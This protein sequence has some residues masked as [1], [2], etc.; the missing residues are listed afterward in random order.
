MLEIS[1]AGFIYSHKIM[2][3]Q[4][5]L[6]T[7]LFILT[8]ASIFL[9]S[10]CSS[11]T[12]DQPTPTTDGFDR[13]IMLENLADNI[14]IPS[15]NN[16]NDKILDLKISADNFSQNI[17]SDNL[18]DLRS[19]WLRAY[20]AWQH[21]E[22]FNIGK[23]EEIYYAF[24][25]NSYPADAARI[26][27]N[28]ES[29]SYDLV[30]QANNHDAQGFPAL[31]YMLYGLSGDSLSV[32]DKYL[33]IEG[34]KY[35]TYLDTLV[36]SM[37]NNT[38]LVIEYWNNNRNTFVSSYDNT[39]TS[40][41]NMLTNDFIYYYEKGL[42]A[43]KIGIPA[44]RYSSGPLSDKVEAYYRKNIS[45]ELALEALS[46]CNKFFIG[47]SFSSL[48]TGESLKTYLDYTNENSTLSDE[49]VSTLANAKDKIEMLNNNFVEQISTNNVAML[50][51]Y[52]A[53][54]VGVV[55]LKTDMLFA[56]NI[57]VDY[58]DADGD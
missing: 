20:K 24:K 1:S 36:E 7:L 11:G 53:V 27:A 14:I 38:N 30:N 28:I 8:I 25:M 15:Y 34:N 47:Q 19:K 10:G 39:A 48:E 17:N 54:Q 33:S 55:K 9:F 12:D 44:G 16:L 51:A 57:S 41:F 4:K 18:I 43:N 5:T 21:V 6:F 23:S 49:I 22:M 50:E 40:S 42:R 2:K 45:K 58:I 35:I 31:D 52:D 26:E 13:K 37:T 56:L 29:N 46:A 3:Q 32:L